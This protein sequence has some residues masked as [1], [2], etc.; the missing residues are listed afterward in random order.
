[1]PQAQ[2][3]VGLRYRVLEFDNNKSQMQTLNQKAKPV[4]NLIIDN[5]D[6]IAPQ[7]EF[8]TTKNQIQAHIVL[9][10]EYS[11]EVKGVGKM[12]RGIR[13]FSGDQRD[14]TSSASAVELQ[15]IQEA[16]LDD[17]VGNMLAA[18]AKEFSWVP[19]EFIP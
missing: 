2:A 4:G 15:S 18:M 3:E 10:N 12:R 19:P 1:M 5:S 8:D 7:E 9:K 13:L 6:V 11:H 17:L 14:I 16:A